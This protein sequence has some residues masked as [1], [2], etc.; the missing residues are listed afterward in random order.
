[1]QKDTL[2]L[3]LLSINVIVF[4]KVILLVEMYLKFNFQNNWQFLT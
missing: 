1:M 4:M 2:Y 3:L